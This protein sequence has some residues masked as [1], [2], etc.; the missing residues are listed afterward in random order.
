MAQQPNQQ[1]QVAF[2]PANG[3][4]DVVHYIAANSNSYSTGSITG[5]VDKSGLTNGLLGVTSAL[6][7][8]TAAQVTASTGGAFTNTLNLPGASAYEQIP[9]T[10]K[11]AGWVALGGGTYTATVQ[12]LIYASTSAGFTASA[13]AAVL[14]AAAVNV[15]IA[16]AAAATLSYFPWEAEVTLSGDSTSGKLVGRVTQM[17][18]NGAQ[19]LVTPAVAIQANLPSSVSF[20]AAT[21]LQ[22]LVG[23][24][25]SNATTPTVNLGSFF[26]ES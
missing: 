24:T 1:A 4:G 7:S 18:Y 20:S 19:Q 10:V 15:T 5:W 14:S 25:L 6:Q 16:V 9:F 12:P 2:G 26:L 17:V 22:F 11:A 8:S 13:A 21:P 3:G 23:V